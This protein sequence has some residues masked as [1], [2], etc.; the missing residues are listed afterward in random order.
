MHILKGQLGQES[1]RKQTEEGFSMKKPAKT[2]RT[3]INSES[4]VKAKQ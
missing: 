4:L 1:S 2:R 3:E